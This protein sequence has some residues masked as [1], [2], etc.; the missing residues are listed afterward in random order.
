MAS[1]ETEI[2][3][4][5]DALDSKGGFTWLLAGAKAFLEYKIRLNLTADA[6]PEGLERDK[7]MSQHSD[8]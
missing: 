3:V 2:K 4:F 1:E 8:D 7:H 5:N 6:F